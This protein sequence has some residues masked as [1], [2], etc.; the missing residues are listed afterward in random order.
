MK[1]VWLR[2]WTFGGAGVSAA[3]SSLYAYYR[4]RIPSEDN[5]VAASPVAII[6][7]S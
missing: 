6:S 4:R 3:K 7:L 1:D 5:R 2:L